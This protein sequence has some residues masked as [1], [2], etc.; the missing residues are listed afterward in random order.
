MENLRELNLKL[1]AESLRKA[2]HKDII[3]VQTIHSIDNLIAVISKLLSNLRERY[4]YYNSES[5][6]IEDQ[7]Q[8][9]NEI[10]KFKKGKVGIDLDKEDL[11]SVLDL[12]EV[13]E[14]LIDTKEK[15][16]KYLETLMKKECPFLLET[17]GPLVGARLISLANDLKHLAELPSSTIQVLGAEKAL[18]RHLKEGARAPKFGVI[19]NHESIS[20]DKNRGKAARHLAAKISIAVKKDYFRKK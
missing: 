10:K 9:L 20:K 6:K 14:K 3:I 5:M 4:G 13:I 11:D 16:E 15:Q 17:A 8:L 1:T 7:K 2:I 19:Y 12:V 18:F